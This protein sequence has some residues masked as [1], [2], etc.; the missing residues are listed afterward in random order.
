MTTIKKIPVAIKNSP[1]KIQIISRSFPIENMQGSSAYMLDFVRYLREAGCNVEY[2]SI[3]PLPD[4]EFPWCVIPSSLGTP[5]SVWVPNNL[6]IGRV[7][8]RFNSLLDWIAGL[9]RLIYRRLPQYIKKIYRAA[10]KKVQQRHEHQATTTDADVQDW[11]LLLP[12]PEEIAFAQTQFN[13]FKPD[14]VVVNYVFLANILDT[15][16]ANENI[17]KVILTHDVFHHRNAYL[18]KIGV[19]MSEGDW[20]REKESEQLRKAQVLLAIQ[21]EDAHVF[22]EMAPQCEVICMPKSA[23]CHSH[24]IKQV[25]GRCLFVGS[26]GQHNYY[27]L[28]WFLENVWSTVLQLNPNCSLHVCGNVCSSIQGTFPNVHLLD[29]VDDLKPEYSA[30]EVCLLPL[31]G[32]SGLK[33]K[34]VEAM[35]YGRACV[36]TSIGVQGLPEIVGKTA[37][38]ADTAEDFAAAIHT[39][40]TNPDK[41]QSM[42]EQARKYVTEKLS[43]KAAYQPFVDRIEEHLQQVANRL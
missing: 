24:T 23:I 38:V 14:V 43:P 36:S 31:L 9:L 1:R 2:I 3:E 40:L 41:R 26:K 29:R 28:Q 15:L 30:A 13:R 5:A 4:K 19:A 16:S 39:L 10:I 6:R 34:L 25:P 33:I 11:R 8:L 35:S 21:Q 22:K 12:T 20:D 7:L 27:G 18:K 17:L 42:E 37:I 32:G